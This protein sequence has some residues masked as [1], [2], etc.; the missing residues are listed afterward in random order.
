MGRRHLLQIMLDSIPSGCYIVKRMANKSKNPHA[1]AL[2]R[3]GG[4]K[5]SARKTEANRQ[6]ILKRWNKPPSKDT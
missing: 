4:Q 5:K 1:V 6:N 2:G 3:R